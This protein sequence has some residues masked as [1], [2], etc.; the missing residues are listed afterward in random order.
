VAATAQQDPRSQ[1]HQTPKPAAAESSAAG[2]AARAEPLLPDPVVVDAYEAAQRHPDLRRRLDR[3]FAAAPATQQQMAAKQQL[4]TGLLDAAWRREQPALHPIA[5]RLAGCRRP[6]SRGAGRPA[7]RAASRGGDSG[8]SDP[9]LDD[10]DPGA[11]CG[12]RSGPPA[13]LLEQEAAP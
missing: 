8:D 11:D 10:P 5:R 6:R 2:D 4:I 3:A 13:W 12:R 1:Q 7:S 9:D